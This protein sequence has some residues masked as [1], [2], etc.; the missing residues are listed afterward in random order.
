MRRGGL[1][2][3]RRCLL[4]GPLLIGERSG[5]LVV[6]RRCGLMDGV[7]IAR[8]GGL[9]EDRRRGWRGLR[10]GLLRHGA[11]LRTY[12]CLLVLRCLALGRDLEA[13]QLLGRQ[14]HA[15]RRGVLTQVGACADD[16]PV[17]RAQHGRAV[18][19]HPA[20]RAPRLVPVLHLLGHDP[21][22]EG[23]PQHD[24]I[25]VPEP[26]L[27]RRVGLLEH[28]PRAGRIIGT[29]MYG[30]ELLGGQENIG[31][32]LTEVGP[33]QV[34]G[35]LEH[36]TRLTQITG[37]GEG[38]RTLPGGE[39]RGRLRHAGHAARNAAPTPVQA[40]TMCRVSPRAVPVCPA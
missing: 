32:I 16:G 37:F 23:D 38:V 14:L 1:V 34:D 3:A 40:V 12:R 22:I 28:P 24:R 19:G 35:M 26:P 33:A 5:G 27:P 6:G 8:H 21:E 2:I 36:S 13:L 15:Y 25:G 7:V 17:I 31:I 9:R 4:L 30:G 18:R 11:G 39:E 10:R 20:E 29:L